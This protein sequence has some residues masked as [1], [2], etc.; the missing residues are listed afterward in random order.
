MASIESW[1]NESNHSSIEKKEVEF[2]TTTTGKMKT[3]SDNEKKLT[4]PLYPPLLI[5]Q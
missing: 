4:G 3:R 2:E 1:G 5:D